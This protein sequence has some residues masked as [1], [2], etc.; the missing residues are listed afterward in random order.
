MELNMTCGLAGGCRSVWWCR[1]WVA[2]VHVWGGGGKICGGIKSGGEW[3][4]VLQWLGA[5]R[6]H[7]ISAATLVETNMC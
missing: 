4:S 3:S 1:G 2:L 7:S 6:A 5:G